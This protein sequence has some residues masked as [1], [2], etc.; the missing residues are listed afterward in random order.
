M[1][2]EPEMVEN[3]LVHRS[4]PSAMNVLRGRL[5]AK[6]DEVLSQIAASDDTPSNSH[7][8][9]EANLVLPQD[10][11]GYSR[12]V[13]LDS[14]RI[15][16]LRSPTTEKDSSLRCTASSSDYVSV[17]PP[18]HSQGY[19]GLDGVP[20]SAEPTHS[21]NTPVAQSCR[22]IDNSCV[23][24]FDGSQHTPPTTPTSSTLPT[25][26]LES[27]EQRPPKRRRLGEDHPHKLEQSTID[28][29]TEGIWEQIHNPKSL[30]MGNDLKEA[31]SWVLEKMSGDTNRFESRDLDFGKAT[32]RCQQITTSS[33]TA[34]AF[35]VIVQAHWVDCYDARLTALREERPELRPNEHKKMVLTEAC[36]SFSWSEKELRNRM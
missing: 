20:A 34:R 29:L 2:R 10:V 36:T 26:H 17:N 21:P 31:M 32:K 3:E 24:L 7:I 35:E 25:C 8:Q 9:F 6:I 15:D 22:P 28:K 23:P 11:T 4:S 19:C 1:F 30:A 13:I 14:I 18:L 12:R 27:E 5:I 16:D 33:R